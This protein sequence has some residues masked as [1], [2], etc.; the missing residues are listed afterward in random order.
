MYSLVNK[1]GAELT[2]LTRSVIHDP[3]TTTSKASSVITY[4]PK[5]QTGPSGYF[6]NV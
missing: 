6:M 5:T 3:T 1:T 4:W 2:H